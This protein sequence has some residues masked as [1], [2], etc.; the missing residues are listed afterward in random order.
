MKGQVFSVAGVDEPVTMCSFPRDAG[1]Y[2]F[3]YVFIISLL[4]KIL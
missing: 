1:A 3:E 2:V 4:Y